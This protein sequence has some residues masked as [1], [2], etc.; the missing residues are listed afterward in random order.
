MATVYI[1]PRRNSCVSES[2]SD[3]HSVEFAAPSGIAEAGS[4][5]RAAGR[6]AGLAKAQMAT[7]GRSL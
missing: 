4:L 5:A 7:D 2:S 6:R 1:L 3:A